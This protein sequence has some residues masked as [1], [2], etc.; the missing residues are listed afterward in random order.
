[1]HSLICRQTIPESVEQV[2]QCLLDAVS[3]GGMASGIRLT[4]ETVANKLAVSRQPVL[5]ALRQLKADGLAQDALTP[6]DRKAV[7]CRWSR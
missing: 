5:Q 4:H 3:D 6:T 1:M 2:C 7:A